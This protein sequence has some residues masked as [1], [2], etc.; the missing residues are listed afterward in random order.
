MNTNILRVTGI[1]LLL[2]TCFYLVA[3]GGS[4][5][6]SDDSWSEYTSDSSSSSTVAG[7]CQPY[8]G[9]TDDPQFDSFCKQAYSYSCIG[10]TTNAKKVCAVLNQWLADVGDSQ[11]AG[12]YCSQYCD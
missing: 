8:S 10:D 1:G 9:P 3:C 12:Q 7:T 11:T 4:D 2:S 5:S 6:S